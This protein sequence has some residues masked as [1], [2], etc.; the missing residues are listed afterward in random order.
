MYDG[1]RAFNN[2]IVKFFDIHALGSDS[3]KTPPP[4]KLVDFPEPQ[5]LQILIAG[6]E[7]GF[8]VDEI[9]ALVSADALGVRLGPRVLR[10]E[11]A[12]LAA[13]AAMQTVWG[14]F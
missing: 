1:G 12:A 11:T 14:D 7:G 13:L 5:G 3:S 9:A 2:E 6:P 10:T 8:D 4:T